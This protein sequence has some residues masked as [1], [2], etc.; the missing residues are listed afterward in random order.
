MFV[1]TIIYRIYFMG[2]HISK[3]CL[4]TVLY[5]NSKKYWFIQYLLKVIFMK[6]NKE[7]IDELSVVLWKLW[8]R[9]NEFIFKN[10]FT[11][12]N[13]LVKEAYQFLQDFIASQMVVTNQLS[14]SIIRNT[15]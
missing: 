15:G 9:M 1:G 3:G 5:E 6:L 8:W 14:N 13:L 12:P 2:M 7:E 10:T 11:H 4:E